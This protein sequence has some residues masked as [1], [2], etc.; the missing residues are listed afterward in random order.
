MLSLLQGVI[1]VNDEVFG[2]CDRCRGQGALDR[3]RGGEERCLLLYGQSIRS[4][5]SVAPK[6]IRSLRS[7]GRYSPSVSASQ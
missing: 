2:S 5:S 6:S 7:T 3:T 4:A 1:D